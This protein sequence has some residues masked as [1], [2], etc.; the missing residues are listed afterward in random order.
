M[1]IQILNKF[2]R[3]NAYTD[4]TIQSLKPVLKEMELVL[5]FDQASKIS[6]LTLGTKDGV[7]LLF[8]SFI[9]DE[10]KESDYIDY[11]NVLKTTLATMFKECNI[12]TV[13]HEDTFSQGY[14]KSDDVLSS[15]KTM[16]RELKYEYDM[17]FDVIQVRQQTWK[18]CFLLD[19]YKQ[20]TKTNVEIAANHYF[21]NLHCV[22]DIYDS[23][24]IFHYYKTEILPSQN[25]PIFKPYK[26]MKIEKRHK[27]TIKVFQVNHIS[28][29]SLT[30]TE[31]TK[32]AKYG[33]AVFQYNNDKWIE[34]N[35]RQLTSQSNKIWVAEIDNTNRGMYVNAI[36][37]NF[38][39]V[40][41][42]DMKLYCIAYR[43]NKLKGAMLDK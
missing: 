8:M 42:D 43:D 34:E 17:T 5:A 2:S 6:G 12:K 30:S 9:R 3:G 21:P 14:T 7:E 29:I 40:P 33:V 24:G 38:D 10:D 36:W 41:E 4:Q 20:P 13:L 27:L 16:F 15:M 1:H 31:L 18:S 19:G 39:I 23:V 28:E 35:C 37:C 25:S 22:Q 26:G 32:K 11:K